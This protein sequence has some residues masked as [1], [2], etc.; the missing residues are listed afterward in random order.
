MKRRAS[1]AA[2][3][4][5]LAQGFGTCLMSGKSFGT[6]LMSGKGSG[7]CLVSGN[8]KLWEMLGNGTSFSGASLRLAR[9]R[10]TYINTNICI[11]IYYVVYILCA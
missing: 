11:Y 10:R 9:G 3:A 4:Q 7:T 5:R 2:L 6:C 8:G 1:E